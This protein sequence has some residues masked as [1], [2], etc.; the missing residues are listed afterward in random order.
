M[1]GPSGIA[2]VT[3]DAFNLDGT[4]HHQYITVEPV[5]LHNIR[6]GTFFFFESIRLFPEGSL[7]L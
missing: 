5:L 2:S 6:Q 4:D 3:S 1:W 7:R